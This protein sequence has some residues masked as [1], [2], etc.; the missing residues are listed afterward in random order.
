MGKNNA[1]TNW[2]RRLLVMVVGG[3]ALL[4]GTVAAKLTATANHA[5]IKID[6]F[7]HG[8]TVS[9]KGECEP[10]TELVIKISSAEGHTVMKKKG[11]VGG[12]LWMNVGDLRFDHLPELYFVRSSKA[13]EEVV[14]PTEA[15]KHIFGFKALESH[16]V[17]EPAETETEKALYFTELVK[18]K[19]QNKLFSQ[20]TGID[21]STENG[22]RFYS[23]V[24]DWPY[25]AKPGDYTVEVYAVKN[26]R[27][28]EAA[29]SNVQVERAGAVKYLADLARNNGMLYGLVS[30]L[31]A[32]LSG[33]GVGAIFG[34]GGGSH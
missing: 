1:L 12:L 10:D 3:L 19:E 21:I 26:G 5:N 8:S 2:G 28:V 4:P 23:T 15:A 34:K 14:V 31:V 17:I 29:S 9:V 22:N 11:K 33:F 7:Y 27:V 24:F 20:D 16:L 6:A 32:L 30:V 18:F 13:L 25:Q